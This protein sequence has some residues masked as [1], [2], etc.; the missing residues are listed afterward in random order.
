MLLFAM[1][2]V[3]TNACGIMG[4]I[5]AGKKDNRYMYGFFL[6][7]YTVLNVFPLLGLKLAKQKKKRK[8][9][10]VCSRMN[11]CFA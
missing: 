5:S 8:D 7:E 2:K 3:V 9:T 1:I 11:A 10:E 6:R 4:N